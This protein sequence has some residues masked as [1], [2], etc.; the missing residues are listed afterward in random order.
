[1]K[2]DFLIPWVCVALIGAGI[3]LIKE[4]MRKYRRVQKIK[5]TP[6]SKVRSAAVGLVEVSGNAICKDPLISPMSGEKCVY[7]K[8]NVALFIHEHRR[9]MEIWKIKFTIGQDKRL[10]STE[11]Y[12]ARSSKQ[13]YLEDKTGRILVDPKWADV[14]VSVTNQGFRSYGR[15]SAGKE[16]S[17]PKLKFLLETNPE[18]RKIL[19][20]YS[21]Y[22]L[23]VNE[24]CIAE[25]DPIY[26]LGSAE[27]LSGTSSEVPNENLIIRANKF[28]KIL[29]ISNRSEKDVLSHFYGN[30]WMD[31]FLGISWVII[32]LYF[33]SSSI[34]FI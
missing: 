2:A 18:L 32:G 21:E 15:D 31:F 19:Q 1:M 29:Y 12:S 27:P 3:Y 5:N 26:V 10:R 28:E 30:M 8:V 33:L 20:E 7:W 17:N 23:D 34:G 14:D 13:F 22:T 24:Y 9:D 6:T 16:S 25:N 11:I 4:G